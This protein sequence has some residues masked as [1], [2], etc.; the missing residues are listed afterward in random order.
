[1]EKIELSI[2]TP[3]YNSANT[4]VRTIN[5]VLNQ[6]LRVEYIIVDACS[7]DDT[8][9][10]SRKFPNIKIICEPDKGVYDAMNKGIHTANGDIIG[11]I[12]SDD[13][14]EPDIL[15]EIVLLFN[16]KHKIGILH[17]DMRIWD[18][19]TF[20]KLQKPKKMAKKNFIKGMPINH[21]T[22]FVRKDV[23]E[24]HGFFNDKYKIA[25]DFDFILCLWTNNVSFYYHNKVITNF[26]LGGISDIKRNISAKE[27]LDIKLKYN[28][29]K[30]LVY[31]HYYKKRISGVINYG[32]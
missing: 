31:I 30:F 19:N 18:N 12:N 10:I 32:S 7:K 15:K 5:S 20:Y 14:Y 1:M 3:T 27:S 24:K 8:V 25:S 26:S 17:G 13:W 23:Y 16:K 11:I 6:N 21:P 9:N 29:N 22:C 2:I 4:I 28:L